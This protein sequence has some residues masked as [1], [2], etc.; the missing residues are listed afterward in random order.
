MLDALRERHNRRSR[1][2]NVRVVPTW[3]A[4]VHLWLQIQPVEAINLVQRVLVQGTQHWHIIDVPMLRAT[5]PITARRARESATVLSKLRALQ[6]H[7]PWAQR[8][9]ISYHVAVNSVAC[10]MLLA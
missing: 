10:L 1:I 3:P 7:F 8:K 5:M 9:Y 2:L 4:T 6:R